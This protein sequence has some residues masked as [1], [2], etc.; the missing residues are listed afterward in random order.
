MQIRP[1]EAGLFYA[2]GWTVSQIRRNSLSLFGI[3]RTRLKAEVP[4]SIP[5]LLLAEG[6]FFNVCRINP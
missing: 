2:D 6:P 3:L 5:R 1:V 4:L